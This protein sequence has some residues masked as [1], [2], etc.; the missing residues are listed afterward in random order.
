[1]CLFQMQESKP[2]YKRASCTKVRKRY[3]VSLRVGDD[4]C[5]IS[6]D[7]VMAGSVRQKHL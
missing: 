1:M 3:G 7:V 6:S 2:M 5:F 4:R